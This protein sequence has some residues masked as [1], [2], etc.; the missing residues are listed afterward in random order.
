MAVGARSTQVW[1]NSE[2]DGVRLITLSIYVLS[3][4]RV[5]DQAA[6]G[7]RRR[8][9]AAFDDPKE[10]GSGSRFGLDNSG[11][12]FSKTGFHFSGSL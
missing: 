7:A 1:E 11:A 8:N 12:I 6:A 3:G 10:A 9:P 5:P 4:A 2:L